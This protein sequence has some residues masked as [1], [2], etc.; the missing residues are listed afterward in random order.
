M[1]WFLAVV[2]ALAAAPVVACTAWW[3]LSKLR[4]RR[5]SRIAD[6]L[7]ET[8][9]GP[10][11]SRSASPSRRPSDT[12]R[13]P[14]R[15]K[16]THGAGAPCEVAAGVR[17]IRHHDDG[18]CDCWDDTIILALRELGLN[19]PALLTHDRRPLLTH[20]APQRPGYPPAAP[21]ARPAGSPS[22][23]P[24]QRIPE[25][26]LPG[27]AQPMPVLRQPEAHYAGRHRLD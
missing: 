23:P 1:A 26:S 22:V 9:R 16:P 24:A 5:K 27:M 10:A 25:W 3:I 15:Q 11:P 6:R 13:Q 18:L 2:I 7:A 14:A 12:R 8:Y 17:Q 20:D 19:E 21:P 4:D